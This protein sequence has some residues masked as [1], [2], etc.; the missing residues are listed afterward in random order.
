MVSGVSWRNDYVVGTFADQV[1]AEEA[2]Q[3]FLS[4]DAKN[5]PEYRS[6]RVGPVGG[7]T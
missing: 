1:W 5:N 6:Y 4:L 7:S 2:G 3:H